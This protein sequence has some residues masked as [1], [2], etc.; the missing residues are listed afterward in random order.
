MWMVTPRRAASARI[1]SSWCSAPS[2]RTTQVRWRC[3]SRAPAWPNAAAIMLGRVV[4]HRPGQP[5]RRRFGPGPQRAAAVPPAGRGDDVVR[6]ARGRLGIVD[7][8]QGGHPLAVRFLPGGQPGPHPALAGG[9]PGGGRAQRP[10]PHHDPLGVGGDH[11]QRRGGARHRDTGGVERGDIG[12]GAHHGLLDL[13]LADHRPA[14]AGDGGVRG[15]ERAA[16]R[17]H[18]G[19]PGQGMGMTAGRQRQGGISRAQV[20]CP[21]AAPGAP[22]DLHRAEQRGQQPAD[23]RSPP[24]S[25]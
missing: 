2:T 16:R 18:G 17:L 12:G 4:P 23:G 15:L 6:A 5:F 19:Q 25:A 7:A 20:R 10:R 3:R 1:R 22:G 24:G 8:G 21:R 14:A 11:Q 9:S 13:P